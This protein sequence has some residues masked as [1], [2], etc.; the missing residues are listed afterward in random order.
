MRIRIGVLKPNR[1]PFYP[2]KVVTGAASEQC[3]PNLI[4]RRTYEVKLKIKI[5]KFQL[6]ISVSSAVV[7]ILL[8]AIP[9]I[10]K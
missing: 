9:A 8:S 10:A 6:T 4:E 5:G 7:F 3:S 1:H 2:Q